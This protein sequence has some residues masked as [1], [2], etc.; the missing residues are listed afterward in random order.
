MSYLEPSRRG[1]ACLSADTD[2]AV[3]LQMVDTT[4]VS[5]RHLSTAPLSEDPR[6]EAI[7]STFNLRV[8]K[9][10][11]NATPSHLPLINLTSSV[12]PYHVDIHQP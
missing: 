8:T 10:R 12:L 3:S 4:A 9:S 7:F 5:A 11:K 2:A 6:R 1:G